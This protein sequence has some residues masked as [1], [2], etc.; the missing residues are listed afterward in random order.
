ML[1]SKTLD[2]SLLELYFDTEFKVTLYEQDISA[3]FKLIDDSKLETIKVAVLSH[4]LI[5]VTP[6]IEKA[7]NYT[8]DQAIEE[9]NESV[10]KEMAIAGYVHDSKID[11]VKKVL[12]SNGLLQRFLDKTN[13]LVDKIEEEAFELSEVVFADDKDILKNLKAYLNR[14]SE[15]RA[16]KTAL[17]KLDNFIKELPVY[18]SLKIP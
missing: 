13:E 1:P 17:T 7:I 15:D 12:N 5:E 14:G 9:K 11:V 16:S 8:V 3:F 10:L 6:L 2:A 4:D 18:P